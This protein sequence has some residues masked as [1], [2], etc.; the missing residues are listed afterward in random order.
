MKKHHDLSVNVKFPILMGIASLV[1]LALV[2]F[3]LMILLH[4]G[5]LNDSITGI[6]LYT[7]ENHIFSNLIVCCLIG[8]VLITLAGAI[9]IRSILRDVTGVTGII[10]Q[11]S[12]GNINLH[13]DGHRNQDEIGKMK[14]ELCKLVERLKHTAD[15]ARSIGEGNLNAEYRLLSD[16]DVLGNS[17]LGMRQSLQTAEKEQ[18]KRAKEEEQR[19]WGTAGLAKFAE[20]LRRDND[21]LE[22]LSHNVISNMVKYLGANQGGIFILN[23]AEREDDKVLEMKAC[24]AFDRRK[25]AEKQIH[26]GEGLVGTCYQEGESIYITEVPDGYINITSGLGD[27]S[28]RAVLICPLKVNDEILGVVELA[29]FREIEPYQLEFV[30][31]VSES[32]AATISAVR[33]KIRTE[34]LL[35]QTKLQAEEMANQEEELRQ[36]MEEMQ[37]TQEEMRRREDELNEALE[38]MKEMMTSGEQY[39]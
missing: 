26:P 4:S 38:R 34:R 23:D 28:P 35:T 19:N 3:L 33:V 24:Y 11:L 15:F 2:C 32:I 14:N 27:A 7:N 9:L 17:L 39:K 6:A 18:L 12:L 21:I 20:I 22:A 25:F 16:D 13:I 5:S 10:R 1:V 31:K 8:V 37:A 29:S 36:N 30:Q